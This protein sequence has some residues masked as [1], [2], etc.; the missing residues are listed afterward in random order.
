LNSISRVLY[1]SLGLAA[2]SLLFAGEF[3]A[4]YSE[5]TATDTVEVKI[6][7]KGSIYRMD[8][9]EEGQDLFIIVNEEAGVTR[10]FNTAEMQYMEVAVNDIR[11]LMQDPFQ[12]SNYMAGIGITKTVGTDTL[13]G[14]VC[15]K[16]SITHQDKKQMTRWMS[17]A[18]DFPL[19]IEFHL[20]QGKFVELW[21]IKEG[22][23]DDALFETPP[24]YQKLEP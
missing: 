12:G 23:V 15:E 10:V 14:Y 9:L 4:N 6:Y 11:S 3:T 1:L 21:N 16:Q 8:I 17:M 19:K 13:E 22:E 5:I 20:A 24:D 2:A 18:L 7:V